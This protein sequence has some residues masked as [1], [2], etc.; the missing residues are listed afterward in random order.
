VP[1]P[2][3]ESTTLGKMAWDRLFGRRGQPAREIVGID[4]DGKEMKLSAFRGK[5]V[6]L[7]F[8]S[9]GCVP[10]LKLVPAE[11]QLI[12]EMKGRPFVMLSVNTDTD[13]KAA[14]KAAAES[15]M[16]W[17]SWWDGEKFPIKE[18]WRVIGVP[19]IWVID[20]K[21]WCG[22]QTTLTVRNSLQS[23]K[24]TSSKQREVHR[25]DLSPI[26]D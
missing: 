9:S 17:R 4:L 15:G 3:K 14:R 11:N 26:P 19:A 16:K 10:C 8:W 12:E 1:G 18:S 7:S 22:R 6:V 21:G 23:W 25:S 13:L 5:V 20:H 24:N 2:G